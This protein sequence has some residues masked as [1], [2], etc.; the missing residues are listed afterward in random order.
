M[1]ISSVVLDPPEADGQRLA[2]CSVAKV[3]SSRNTVCSCS[4]RVQFSTVPVVQRPSRYSGDSSAADASAARAMAPNRPSAEIQC[5][6]IRRLPSPAAG[7][8]L[9]PMLG[10]RASGGGFGGR[11]DERQSPPCRCSPA[12]RRPAR[13]SPGPARLTTMTGRH[14]WSAARSAAMRWARSS[15]TPGSRTEKVYEPAPAP[16]YYVPPRAY[17][18]MTSTASIEA[19]LNQLDKLA[20]AGYITP[21]EYQT[22]RKRSSAR[23]EHRAGPGILRT[24]GPTQLRCPATRSHRL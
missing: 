10:F 7:M 22:R 12:C 19:Q 14:R 13:P 15:P 6:T 3:P 17:V 21:A 11:R 4:A 2:A 1:C 18:P 16:V 24:G 20:A 5:R 23:P 9:C 8:V